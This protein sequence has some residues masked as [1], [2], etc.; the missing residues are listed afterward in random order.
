MCVQARLDPKPSKYGWKFTTRVE[1]TPRGSEPLIDQLNQP[2][3]GWRMGF[4]R[5]DAYRDPLR[6]STRRSH[7]PSVDSDLFIGSAEGAI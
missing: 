1:V 7:Q 4:T 6:P 2:T 5:Q 3:D